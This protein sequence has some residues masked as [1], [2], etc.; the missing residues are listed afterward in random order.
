VLVVF[1]SGNIAA[2]PMPTVCVLQDAGASGGTN[3]VALNTQ[4]PVSS[5]NVA[6]TLTATALQTSLAQQSTAA[7]QSVRT[8]VSTIEL[9]ATTTPTAVM[10]KSEL[11]DFAK[12]GIGVGAAVGGL[13]CLMV[14]MCGILP[15]LKKRKWNEMWNFVC[16]RSR[17]KRENVHHVKGSRGVWTLGKENKA[18][19]ESKES[20]SNDS[21]SR[22]GRI[23]WV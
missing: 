18:G 7:F 5:V 4:V 11:S 17:P 3:A 16:G 6:A 23:V 10:K 8:V 13:F 21:D 1:V 9:Q 19:R 2:N 20:S 15:W 22:E 12:T 14:I